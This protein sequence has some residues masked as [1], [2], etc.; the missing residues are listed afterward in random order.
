MTVLYAGGTRESVTYNERGSVI[1]STD[2]NGRRTTY[3]Y[4]YIAFRG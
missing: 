3:Q 2:A 4:V 1:A